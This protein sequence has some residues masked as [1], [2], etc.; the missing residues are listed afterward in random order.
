VVAI[1]FA[2][3]QLRVMRACEPLLLLLV[4]KVRSPIPTLVK[5][6]GMSGVQPRLPL[7][8]LFAPASKSCERALPGPCLHYG[9]HAQP[10]R[11]LESLLAR[12]TN[13]ICAVWLIED[14][15]TPVST[16]TPSMWPQ[17]MPVAVRNQF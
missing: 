4:A 3:R 17:R 15:R 2:L 14:R 5:A 1:P 7:Q 12:S 9:V 11:H 6:A 8:S 13:R 16:T 10:V